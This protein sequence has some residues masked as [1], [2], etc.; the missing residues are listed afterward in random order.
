MVI[1][2]L[3]LA[4]A[5]WVQLTSVS[6]VRHAVNSLDSLAYDIQLRAKIYTYKK[7]LTTQV[8]IVDIDDKSLSKEGRWPW[9]RAKLADL[10]KALQQ[11][12]AVVV[13]FDVI[14]PEKQDNIATIVFDTMKK[15]SVI[16]PEFESTI[17][18]IEPLF[19]YDAQ[20]AESLQLLDVALGITFTPT[21]ATEGII[22]P[23]VLMLTTPA[24]KQEL[25]FITATGYI[26][27]IPEFVQSAKNVGFLN[28]F[29]DPD[30]VMRRA[31]LLIRYQDGLYPSL[32]LEATRLFLLG[33]LKIVTAQYGDSL[34]LEGVQLGSHLIPTDV[35]AQVI[36]PFVGKSY[37]LPFY[38]ATD[39]LNKKIPSNAL[40]GKIIFV[41]TSATGLGDLHAAAVQAV[42]PGV[43]VQASIANGILNNAFSYKPAWSLGAEL[44]A[45][46][47]VGLIMLLLFPFFG[48]KMLGTFL[49]LIPVSLLLI[50]NWI[51][52]TTGLIFSFLIPMLLPIILAMVNII[53]GYLFESRR[54]E[55][56]KTMFGQY[57]PEKHIDAML[58]STGSYG[59]TGEDR[60]MTVLFADIRN[61]TTISE[62]LTAS[63][64]K[65]LLSEF[66]TPMTEIIFKYQGTIDKYVGDLIMAFWGAPLKDKKH[67]QHA[68]TAALDMQAAVTKLQ[69]EFAERQLPEIN[70]GIGLNS[71]IMSVGDMGSKFRRN[72]TVLG[73]AVNLASRVEGLTKYYGVKIMVTEFTIKNQ[74]QFVFRQ[75]DRV[76]VKGKKKGIEIY[77]VI[78][79]SSDASPDL[80]QEVQQS[81][82][83][84]DHYFKQDWEKAQTLFE[85]LKA[86]YPDVKLYQLY[87]DRIETYKANPPPAD[88]DGV[89]EHKSK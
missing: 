70:I 43:E 60:E 18:K 32:A 87:L 24:E 59:L 1:G 88:W 45:T 35:K 26:T 27:G 4:F 25:G 20:F 62:P 68:L 42:Y 6:G 13:A 72:Y 81:Q 55:R 75:L 10:M 57:V 76:R 79:R 89:Y 3:V 63:Q 33:K 16:T 28:A 30:G 31:P 34:R 53:Y 69:K 78:C 84:L 61:F 11:Y 67:A 41:G 77:E 52:S 83:A 58:K 86:S 47:I 49:V 40:E 80:L 82:Q 65:D 8:A 5:I 39:V 23:P 71:G 36:I 12:G 73:D 66:F 17:K 50:N 29:P 15:N 48:P 22:P 51:W 74:T 38:S 64:L 19:N 44:F 2:L 85:K 46:V 37:T 56:L 7:N 14:F 9:S 21:K 54:R